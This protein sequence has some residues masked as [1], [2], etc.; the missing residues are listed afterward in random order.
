MTG[1]WRSDVIAWA[2][3]VAAVVV[4]VATGCLI[5]GLIP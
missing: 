3:T 1:R 4:I 2:C 5:A